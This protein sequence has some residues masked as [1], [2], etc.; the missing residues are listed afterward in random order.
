MLVNLCLCHGVGEG[1]QGGDRRL[2][3]QGK[4]ESRHTGDEK[5][6]GRIREGKQEQL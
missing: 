2:E 6:E 5:R 3:S 1:R 4:A